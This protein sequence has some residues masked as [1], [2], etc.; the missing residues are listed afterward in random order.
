M[1]I[2]QKWIHNLQICAFTP[3]NTAAKAHLHISLLEIMES[4][5]PPSVQLKQK[6][7]KHS[8]C[9]TKQQVQLKQTPNK[10]AYDWK[11]APKLED[12]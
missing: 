6:Y 11:F 7:I 2:A 8:I 4:S 10:Y 12:N 3:N 1:K 9:T 5:K